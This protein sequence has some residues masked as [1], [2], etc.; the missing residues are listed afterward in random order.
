LQS[1]N[2]SVGEKFE[3]KVEEKVEREDED[4]RRNLR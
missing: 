2:A 4:M 3:E 1:F